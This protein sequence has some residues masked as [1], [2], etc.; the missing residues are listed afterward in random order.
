MTLMIDLHN[1]SG[2]ET[3]KMPFTTLAVTEQTQAHSHHT[4]VEFV[5]QVAQIVRQ[6]ATLA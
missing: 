1:S 5:G 3:P 6:I 2:K 4:E